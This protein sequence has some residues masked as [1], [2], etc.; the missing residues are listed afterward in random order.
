VSKACRAKSLTGKQI[1][2]D[3]RASDAA[4]VLEDE[5]RLFESAFLTGA[6]QIEHNI[7]GGE[8]MTEVG[9]DAMHNKASARHYRSFPG[10]HKTKSAACRHPGKHAGAEVCKA[11]L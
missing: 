9:H 3:G 8:N 6:F 11:A 2:R 5:S 1:I 4:V 7:F 10:R